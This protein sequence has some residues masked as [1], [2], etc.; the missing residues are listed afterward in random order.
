MAYLTKDNTE[1]PTTPIALDREEFVI[2]RHPDCQIIVDEGA[3]SRRHAR[4]FRQ[5]GQLMLED[6][7]SRN[8]TYLNNQ[9]VL[10]PTRLLDGDMIGVCDAK[11]TFHLSLPSSK[12][13]S[14]GKP[15]DR[16]SLTQSDSVLFE[17]QDDDLSSIMSK[18]ELS[19]HYGVVDSTFGITPEKRLETIVN[20]TRA[21]SLTVGTEQVLTTVLDCL[22]E[23]FVQVDRG[24]IVLRDAQG[25]LV[26]RAV[27]IR[28]PKDDELIRVSR[29]IVNYV[30]QRKQAVISSD[31]GTD[32]RFDMSQ[33]IADFRIR[34]LM[35][36]PLIDSDDN[37]FGVIQLDTLRR[38]SGFSEQDLEALSVVSMQASLAIE[39]DRLHLSVAAEKELRR[40]LELAHEVQRGF[41]PQ[42]QPKIPGYEFFDYYRPA[43]QVGGDYYDYIQLKDGRVAVLVA[44]VVGHG[45]AAALLMA[46]LSAEARF[47]LATES[48]F[49]KAMARLNASILGLPLDRFI[50]LIVAMIDPSTD[51]ITMIN[52]GHIQA[53]IRR[54]NGSIIEPGTEYSSLPIGVAAQVDYHP[55][56]VIFETGD[57]V[58]LLTD[59]IHECFNAKQEQFGMARVRQV[60]GE[61]GPRTSQEIGESLVRQV[62]Q[63]VGSAD[64]ND[65]ICLVCF[66]KP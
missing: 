50:T 56:T 18:M 54:K 64:H 55:Y 32:N 42:S 24:F 33:S 62:E 65:D 12:W 16:K 19:S 17:D 53:I 63:F 60:V 66:G 23:L 45:I 15:T 20:V 27:K 28:N 31:A 25:Q 5:G 35:C 1:G 13:K 3:I 58:L 11:F 34:S 39:N 40:D 21:L 14:A 43:R 47:A 2:G 29:T 41:L 48:D 8:G 49:P 51:Q 9:L 7:R 57:S 38:T 26:P 22:F 30:I 52:A 59:G 46:K 37:A 61:P 10:Q 4:I 44:D 6:L 36:A